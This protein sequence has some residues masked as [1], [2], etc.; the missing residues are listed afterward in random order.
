[1]GQRNWCLKHLEKV[2][3]LRDACEKF[4]SDSLEKDEEVWV[5]KQFQPDVKR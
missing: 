5:A 2:S 4:L 1:M 3:G